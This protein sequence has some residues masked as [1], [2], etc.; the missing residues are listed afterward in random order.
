LAIDSPKIVM[1]NETRI[2]SDPKLNY[3]NRD[4]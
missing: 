2:A 1:V 4:D 3:P